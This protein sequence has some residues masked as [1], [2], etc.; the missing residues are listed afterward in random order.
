MIELQPIPKGTKGWKVRR[1]EIEIMA[2][3]QRATQPNTGWDIWQKL[4]RKI[5]TDG[6]EVCLRMKGLSDRGHLKI[7]GNDVDCG[8]F[9][10]TPTKEMSE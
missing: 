3:M 5:T 9:Y 7:T 10:D 1:L 2:T 8:Y 4:K 6:D